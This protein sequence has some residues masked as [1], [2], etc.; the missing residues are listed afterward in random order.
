LPAAWADSGTIRGSVTTSSGAVANDVRVVILELNRDQFVDEAGRFE[1]TDVPYGEYHVQA[2]SPRFG[3]TVIELQLDASTA[4]QQIELGQS[5]HRERVVVTATRSGRGSAEVIQ[6]VNVLDKADLV[7]T[8]QPTIGETLAQEPGVRATYFGPGSSRPII[9]G[10]SGGRVRVLEG[11]L[12]VGDASTTS[13]DHAVAV[14]PFS[15]EQV[16]IL[17][18]PSTLLYGGEAV[19]GVVNIIDGRIPEYRAAKALTG[20]IN[21][22]LGSVSD[23]KASAVKLDGGGG[24]FAWH[25]D[26]FRRDSNDYK[27]PGFAVV[28]DPLSDRDRIQNSSVQ[29][30]G[31]SLGGSW[32]M[33]NGF[34]GASVKR[35]TTNYGIPSS[36]EEVRIDL[37]QTR[38][39]I[40]G[41]VDL[42]DGAIDG[43]RFS[44]ATID[45][46]HIEFE[47]QMVGTIFSN[48]ADEARV[49][50]T[51]GRGKRWSGVFGAQIRNRD[52]NAI[53]AEAFV[54]S[55][56]TRQQALFAVQEF[57]VSGPLRWEFG[58]RA[59]RT[60]LSTPVTVAA[61]PACAMPLDRDFDTLSG[62]AGLAWIAEG[63]LALGASLTHAARSP[64]A[65][66]LY[67][68]GEHVA[69]QSF[70][71]GDPNLDIERANGLD[72]SLRKRFGRASGEINLFH[73]DY[74][75]YIYEFDSGLTDPPMDPMGLPVFQFAQQGA[76]FSGLEL[77]SLFELRHRENFD[78]DLE[79]IGDYVRAELDSG[80]ATPRIPPLSLGI[81]LV[82]DG[83]R[84]H[85]AARLRWHDDQSRI[86]TSETSTDSYTMVNANIGYRIASSGRVQ[87][88]V[89][90]LNNLTN[91]EARPHTSR[92][93]DL[94][95]LPGREIGLTYRL[96]F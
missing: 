8:M 86:A 59:E 53:G 81:G 26:F 50:L 94:T 3:S 23:E 37:E 1:F 92:L 17:R 6:P 47:D 69:T 83:P 12:G 70:E 9:R 10:Q 32:L 74:S 14:D 11:G 43:V 60:E 13:P 67:S 85:G 31:G 20:E 7:A 40:R 22:Q 16:E 33:D 49:E 38:Y 71:L 41:G 72:L 91:E 78:L 21:L 52:V 82:F 80:E 68:C 89:L 77:N 56:S 84:W 64:N 58:L 48:D 27:I 4:A 44:L 51:H 90:R 39:D 36:D 79:L 87:D 66:E 18:G 2:M 25:G 24:D 15:A 30:N 28:G 42:G 5:R 62:S 76:T 54:P 45:Y 61:Q 96:I 95:P 29:S 65:E 46:E 34:V 55:N 57:D 35:F 73:Y 88:I 19:G 75:D 93:K 63:G